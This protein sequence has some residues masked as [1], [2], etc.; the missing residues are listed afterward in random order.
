MHLDKPVEN[1]EPFVEASN[2]K[3]DTLVSSLVFR[4]TLLRTLL[5]LVHRTY[6]PFNG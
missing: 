5:P 1:K 6:H 2:P 4:F 3:D